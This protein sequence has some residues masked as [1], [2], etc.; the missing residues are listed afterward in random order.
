MAKILSAVFTLL[1]L[2]GQPLDAQTA[3]TPRTEIKNWAAFEK[4]LHNSG[5]TLQWI[6]W[7]E[8]AP[9]ETKYK[10]GTLFLKSE[11]VAADGIGKLSID[12]YVVGIDKQNFV[13][14]GIIRITDTPDAGRTCIKTGD[15]LFGITQNRKYWRLREFEWCDGLTDYVDIYF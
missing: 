9:V 12:G 10:N 14:R 6:G 8:R 4:L 11:Q 2:F 5:M 7:E 1:F 3:K 13:F 15:S